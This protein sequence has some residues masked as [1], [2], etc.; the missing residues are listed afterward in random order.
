MAGIVRGPPFH[1][2]TLTANVAHE[3]A[4]LEAAYTTTLERFK[5]TLVKARAVFEDA[6]TIRLANGARVRAETILIARGAWP[7][8]GPKIPGLEHAISSNEAFHLRELP[9]RIV[10]Q[11]GGYIA[12]EFANIFA[13]LGSEVTLVYRGENILRGFAD[14]IREHLRSEMTRRGITII[15]GHIVA[16][17][18]RRGAEFLMRLSDNRRITADK[19]MFALGRRPDLGG[20]GC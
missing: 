9:R 19:V 16:A 2:R 20:R 3:V 5:V 13:G 6:H 11:G 1:W 10:I 12:V 15:C 8:Y 7:H 14:D 4:R 18:E 17:I